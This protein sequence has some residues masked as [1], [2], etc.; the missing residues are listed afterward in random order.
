MHHI[1]VHL[2][3][4][5]PFLTRANAPPTAINYSS[6]NGSFTPI[7]N[8][9]GGLGVAVY[10]FK[11]IQHDT[12]TV[13]PV[14]YMGRALGRCG[15]AGGPDT[16]PFN[17]GWVQRFTQ[18]CLNH[19]QCC[20]VTMN[21]PPICGVACLDE[22]ITAVPGF[23]FAP[24]CGTTAGT[25]KEDDLGPPALL[26]VGS[27]WTIMGGDSSAFGG[28]QTTFPG[29]VAVASVYG[30]CNGFNRTYSVTGTRNGTSVQFTARNPV[31]PDPYCPA[32]ATFMGS[33]TDCNKATGSWTNSDGLSGSWSWERTNTVGTQ[34]VSHGPNA[35]PPPWARRSA[36]AASRATSR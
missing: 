24:D 2:G 18:E 25:W 1:V 29:T 23:F 36:N 30:A 15:T 33:F 27:T 6:S 5:Q 14:C 17:I 3:S 21:S 31:S 12:V 19:D 35:S 8:E 22:F 32:S 9:I 7:C 11:G 28:G 13:G 20:D 26:P 10:D 16:F 4:L 34:I